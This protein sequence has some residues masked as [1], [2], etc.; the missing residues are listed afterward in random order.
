MLGEKQLEADVA[1]T[2]IGMF[3]SVSQANHAGKGICTA[4]VSTSPLLA[5]NLTAAPPA[6]GDRASCICISQA[7]GQLSCFTYVSSDRRCVSVSRGRSR[8]TRE[9]RHRPPA[10]LAPSPGWLPPG[11][12]PFHPWELPLYVALSLVLNSPAR[13]CVDEHLGRSSL[14]FPFFFLFKLPSGTVV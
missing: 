8:R 6:L 10:L 2:G 7:Q 12:L 14:A 13:S 11:W 9:E 1:V 3:A 4:F 5:S